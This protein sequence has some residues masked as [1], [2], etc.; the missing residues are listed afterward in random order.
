M[1]T[2]TIAAI[3]ATAFLLVLAVGLNLQL[4]PH[5]RRFGFMVAEDEDQ[6]E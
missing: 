3:G 2:L 5:P 6:R 4:L 1:I